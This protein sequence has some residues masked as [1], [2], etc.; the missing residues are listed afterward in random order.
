MSRI[1]LTSMPQAWMALT[2]D[3]LP[4]PGPEILTSTWRIPFSL[5]ALAAVVA[6]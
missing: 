3:S 6:A 5:A 4:P 1:A 2:E